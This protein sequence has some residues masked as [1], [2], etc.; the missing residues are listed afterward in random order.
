MN[1]VYDDNDLIHIR[2]IDSLIN[3]TSY[4]K[5]FSFSKHN[6]DYMING[7]DDWVIFTMDVGYQYSNLILDTYVYYN[8]C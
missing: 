4:D 2:R 6:I 1:G 5:K 8:N 3:V 7:L